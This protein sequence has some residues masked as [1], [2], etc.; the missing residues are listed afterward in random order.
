MSTAT[1]ATCYKS[2]RFPVEIISRDVW[3]SLRFCLSFR[4]F[5]ELLKSYY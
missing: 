1:L 2:H 4:D 3:L 5:E